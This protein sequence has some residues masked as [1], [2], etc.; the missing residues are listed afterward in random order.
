MSL[1]LKLLATI[2]I[3]ASLSFADDGG[4]K[5]ENFIKKSFSGNQNIKSLKV[6]VVNSFELKGHKGWSAYQV[7]MDAILKKDGRQLVQKMFWYTNGDLITKELFDVD[8]AKDMADTINIPFKDEFY[9]KENLISGSSASRH[10]IAIFS[11]PLCPFCKDFV[12][13]AI[14]EMKK[15]PA[16][17]AIYY[18]HFPLQSIHPASVELAQAA[19]AYEMKSKKSIIN[20]LYKV[21]INPQERTN[22][23]ILA[24]F[25]KATGA[26]ISMADLMNPAVIKHFQ[27][28]LKIADEMLVNGTPTVF[29]DGILDRTKVKYKEVK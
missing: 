10:K 22:E 26:K 16:R 18:Y 4:K 19:I 25:N 13:D 5:V 1:M 14:E 28:D 20:E 15:D 11:D 27:S 24:E 2:A 21:N 9:K 7:E 12:P 29:V 6:N 3:L 8:T 17:Y 23:K